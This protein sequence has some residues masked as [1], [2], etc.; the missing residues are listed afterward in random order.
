MFCDLGKARVYYETH[1][2]GVPVLMIHGFYPDHLLMKGCMEPVF[3][4]RPGWKRIYFDLPGMGKTKSESWIDSSDKMLEVVL[5]FSERVIPEKNFLVIGESYGGYLAR[6]V[7][8]KKNK[9]VDGLMLICP[10]VVPKP[11]E[12]TLPARKVIVE[13]RKL[14]SELATED[15]FEF[16]SMAVVQNRLTWERFRDEILVGVRAADPAFLKRLLLKAYPFSFPVDLLPEPYEKPVLIL[17]GRQDTSVG[18]ADDWGLLS[19]YPRATFAVLDMAGHNLQIE[20]PELFS[21]LTTEWLNRVEIER[22]ATNTL[23]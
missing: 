11:E 17:A 9:S 10:V 3:S 16:A 13:D 23:H 8:A 20:Q 1:G 12:R 2:E 15:A 4:E 18:Y 7:I 22:K 19:N 5:S 6:G 21:A 14:V